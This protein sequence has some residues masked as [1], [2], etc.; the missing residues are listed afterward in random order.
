MQDSATQ[1]ILFDLDGTLV[2]TIEDIRM[3]MNVALD[4]EK[5][6]PLT[7]EMTK[8]VVGRGLRNALIAACTLRF[9]D[10]SQTRLNELYELMMGH[11]RMHYADKSRSYEGIP[12]LL[13]TLNDRNLP[14]G[15]F[16]NKEDGLTK[17]IV[18]KMFPSI[19]FV[20]VRGMRDDYP[21]KPDKSGVLRFIGKVGIEM[22]NLLYVGDSEVDYQT[23][24]NA[25]CRHVLVTWGFRPKEELLTIPDAHLVDSVNELE[26]AIYGLQRERSEK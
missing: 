10:V 7:T 25:G 26:D 12:S 8:Q 5:L 11:Y 16:S 15:I 1:A 23:S 4:A 21:R 19:Q 22:Q 18:S 20:W 6:E 9:R 2:D 14:I 17:A 24:V 13:K 3:A